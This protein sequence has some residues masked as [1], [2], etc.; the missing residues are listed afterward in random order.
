M[1]FEYRNNH[2]FFLST[3]EISKFFIFLKKEG[4][5]Q[6]QSNKFYEN[7]FLKYVK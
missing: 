5:Q 7:I 6:P 1:R 3:H 2:A 4:F